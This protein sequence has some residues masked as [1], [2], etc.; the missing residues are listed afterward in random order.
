MPGTSTLGLFVRF[1][2]KLL[3]EALLAPWTLARVRRSLTELPDR[4]DAL[5]GSLEQTTGMLSRTLPELDTRLVE[6]ADDLTAFRTSL[7]ALLPELSRVVSGMDERFRNVESSVSELG[8]GVLSVLGS[9]PGVRRAL[10]EPR[11]SAPPPS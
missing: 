1:P 11:S 4:I 5:R 6:V 8:N 9:I 3:E 10:R 7:E 2:A